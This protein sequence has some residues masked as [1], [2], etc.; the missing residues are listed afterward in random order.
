MNNQ[1]KKNNQEQKPE[2]SYYS[3]ITADVRY[4]KELTP[5]ANLLYG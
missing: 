3:V 5:N 1:E 2:P 4:D